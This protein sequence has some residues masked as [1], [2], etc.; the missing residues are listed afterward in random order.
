M[1]LSIVIDNLDGALRLG[2]EIAG[3]AGEA[4][5]LAMVKVGRRAQTRVRRKL[6]A[7]LGVRG[8]D[9]NR[10]VRYFGIRR[11]DA[12]RRGRHGRRMP[13]ARLWFGY[14]G[15]LLHPRTSAY[16]RRER[17]RQWPRSFEANVKGG[18]LWFKR[19]PNPYARA[20]RSR[21]SNPSPLDRPNPRHHS[22]PIDRVGIR[23][24]RRPAERIMLAVSRAS[25]RA[26][27]AEEYDRQFK[28]LQ[29]QRAERKVA[30]LVRRAVT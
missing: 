6:R 23:V 8:K 9:L 15:L 29:K 28:R 19:R 4:H 2:E 3:I 18:R 7:F 14:G 20:P 11:G 12:A 1:T 30:N 26:H 13:T 17:E 5:A 22:L 25:M 16:A 24:P 21:P 27:Y 10:H